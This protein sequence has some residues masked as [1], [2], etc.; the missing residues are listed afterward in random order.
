MRDRSRHLTIPARAVFLG[1]TLGATAMF[2]E[3]DETGRSTEHEH[4]AAL[5]EIRIASDPNHVVLETWIGGGMIKQPTH[6]LIHA[7]GHVRIANPNRLSADQG[8]YTMGLAESDLQVLLRM[9]ADAE[10]FETSTAEIGQLL[11]S[12]RT[13]SGDLITV[14]DS[15]VLLIA[16]SLESFQRSAHDEPILGLEHTVRLPHPGFWAERFPQNERFQILAKAVDSL[17][18]LT[19]D[20][21]LERAND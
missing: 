21:R 18:A 13:A 10:L 17:I 6:I 19:K 7:G 4:S 14:S 2:A 3:A 20:D 15:V 9:L 16:V 5:S 12:Q 8:T 1:L 11:G